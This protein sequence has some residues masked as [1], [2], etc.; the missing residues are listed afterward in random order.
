MALQ[1]VTKVLNIHFFLSFFFHF[2]AFRSTFL[3]IYSALF[4]YNK[5]PS[6]IGPMWLHAFHFCAMK[7]N[8]LIHCSCF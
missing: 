1:E 6:A 7:S 8:H 3:L 2:F 5:L 4:L